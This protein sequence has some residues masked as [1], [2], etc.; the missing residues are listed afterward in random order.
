M[1]SFVKE[2]SG[3]PAARFFNF[4]EDAAKANMNRG[5]MNIIV[6]EN[7]K[8]TDVFTPEGEDFIVLES[9]YLK[10]RTL[11][12]VPGRLIEEAGSIKQAPVAGECIARYKELNASF[13]RGTYY[14]AK[15]NSTKEECL[16]D[17]SAMFDNIN[18]GTLLFQANMLVYL[19]AIHENE[20]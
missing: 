12:E 11:R 5:K 9:G 4:T 16:H 6:V 15:E 20:W 19:M 10:D 17:G 14:I 7:G 8:V 3:P 18:P 1:R 13:N 2:P